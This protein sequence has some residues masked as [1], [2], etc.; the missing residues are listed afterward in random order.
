VEIIKKLNHAVNQKEREAI[1]SQVCELCDHNITSVH[2]EELAA[3]ADSA[4][5][6]HL[7]FLRLKE[8]LEQQSAVPLNHSRVAHEISRT[9]EA[10][11]MVYRSSP[12][13]VAKSF[14]SVGL[15]VVDLLLQVI[16][17]QLKG[18]QVGVG[19]KVESDT[20]DSNSVD[21]KG[22]VGSSNTNMP[23][24]TLSSQ[25]RRNPDSD[26]QLRI[27][28]KIIAHFAR[29]GSAT[30]PMAHH[31][32]LL[33]CLKRVVDCDMYEIPSEARL[34]SLWIIAN[35]ACNADNMIMMAWHPGLLDSL[36]WA[37]SRPTYSVES[38]PRTMEVL[39][40]HSIAARALLNLSWSP[41]NKIPMSEHSNLVDVLSK[42]I[43]CRHTCP[44]KGTRSILAQTRCHAVGALRNIAA[45]PRRNKIR[46][47]K[48]GCG[49]VLDALT[50][51]VLYDTD[52]RIKSRAFAA[53]YNLACHDT[54]RTIVEKPA[55]LGALSDAM[56]DTS[57]NDIKSMA[58]SV[59]HS[60]EKSITPDMA[61]YHVLRE[62][63]NMVSMS[64]EGEHVPTEAV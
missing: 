27:A 50:D 46:L 58:R 22:S 62:F 51:A 48:H 32:G 37:S 14:V 12:D 26:F 20:E 30:Q 4:L 36:V 5:T 47:C 17:F 52:P 18:R 7:A 6:K 10:L 25:Q 13:A 63:L 33:A 9:L 41:E 43:V 16:T 23:S 55:L 56:R 53:V 35:L 29:V 64:E 28:T 31:S 3:G 1:I 45:A 44:N 54:A 61:C 42:M 24:P 60:L 57:S 8:Q 59:L 38:T 2:E 49:R 34:N 21:D 11:E 40:T 19:I 39:R 15:E